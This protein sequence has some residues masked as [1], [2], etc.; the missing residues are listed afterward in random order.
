[1]AESS[2]ALIG[3]ARKSGRDDR[4]AFLVARLQLAEEQ[5]INGN[6]YGWDDS[7]AMKRARA[8]RMIREFLRPGVKS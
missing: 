1:M 5:L 6:R 7:N 4:I 2:I 8:V 3:E